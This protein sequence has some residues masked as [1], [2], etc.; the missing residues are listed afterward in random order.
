MA[1]RCRLFC[2]VAL[3]IGFAGTAGRSAETA[4][5]KFPDVQ[6]Q[7][8][9]WANVD[10]WAS[11]DH[12]A[13]FST[14]LASCRAVTS[15]RRPARDATPVGEALKTV[16]DRAFAALPLDEDGARKFFED[17]FRP[18]RINKLSDTAG[19]LTGYYE[20]IIEGSRVPTGQ[21]TAPL[22]RR[23]PN[24]V[25]AGRRKLGD[26]FPSKGVKVGRRVGRRKIVPYYDRGEI[27]NGALDGWHLEICW[28]HDPVDV[29]FAQIQG[30]ARIR[31]EDG[32]ILRVN[33]DSHNGWPYTPVGRILIERSQ[34]PKDEMSMQ[35]IREWME[36]N[37][38][39][40]KE[41]R[42]QNKS[43]VFFR[44]TDLATEDEAVGAEG[45]PLVPGRSIAVDR[46]L[47]IYGTPFFIAADLPI[48]NEKT[49]TKFRRLV[50]A[51]DT[52]SAIVGPARA[53]IYFGAGDEAARMAG[54][55]KNPGDFLMLLPRE[56]DPV[57]AGRDMPL[58]AERPNAFSLSLTTMDDPTA[59][60][61]PL[62]EPKPAIAPEPKP[63]PAVAAAAVPKRN[64]RPKP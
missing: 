15:K 18:L 56:L 35:R 16:C 25:V 14:F 12:A 33:Y 37:P 34:V 55:I 47:H 11:D 46:A 6:Y 44:I 39:A 57:E 31:L 29:L 23:P 42:A 48:A 40:A 17:N 8:L 26:A 30:S 62:P 22:Y 2:L 36:A 24:L 3:L 1:V 49:A 32:T 13:A 51:Q 54:R 43:Y 21:F 52:G 7:P 58:P 19:F 10:G 28:L 64:P 53:D 60:D 4:P 41:V 38:D 63:K 20:P 61:V 9:D 59:E 5:I 45:V 27:E 50:V